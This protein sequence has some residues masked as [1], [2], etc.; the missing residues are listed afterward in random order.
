MQLLIK[1]TSNALVFGLNALATGIRN[2]EMD[3][4]GR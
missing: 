4:G 1:W 3:F 2:F